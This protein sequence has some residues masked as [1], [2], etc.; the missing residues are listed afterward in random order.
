MGYILIPFANTNAPIKA[1]A[2]I[3]GQLFTR[4]SEYRKDR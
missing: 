4:G 3:I 2:S 1:L